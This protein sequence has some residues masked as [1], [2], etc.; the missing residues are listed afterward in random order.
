MSKAALNYWV[1]S[2]TGVAF[3]LCAATGIVRLFPAVASVSDAGTPTILAV[4]ASLW[5][6]V[7]DWS[8]VAM[9]AGVGLH[10]A[11]HLRWFVA[12]TRKI[13]R[14]PATPRAATTS[15]AAALQ[16]LE[17][18][19]SESSPRQRRAGHS[20]RRTTRRRFLVGAGAVGGAALLVGVGLAGAGWSSSSPGGAATVEDDAT[21]ST[22]ESGVTA[23]TTA[24][25]TVDAGRCA[26]CGACVETC[27]HGVFAMSS[28]TAVA[29]YPQAC[30]LC[31]RCLQACGPAAIT[32]NG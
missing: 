5:L 2:A 4:P 10:M 29:S 23:P 21:Q 14:A 27:P 24:R 26:G 12:M 3:L 11:L 15:A 25:V 8:G 20:G 16:R 30:S 6:F 9:A 17:R 31:G 28:A 19:G 7:H 18:L 13:A 1:D 22:G 32:L